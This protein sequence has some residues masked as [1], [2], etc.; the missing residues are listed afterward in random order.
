MGRRVWVMGTSGSG[1]SSL[2][3]EIAGRLG[4]EHVELDGIYHQAGWV[5]LPREEFR[6]RVEQIVAGDEWVVDGNYRGALAEVVW[7]RV[8]TVVWFD[9]PRWRVMVQLVRRTIVRVVTRQVLWN[10]NREPWGNLWSVDPDKSV[11]AWAWTTHA[12]NRERHLAALVDPRYR[13][14]EFVRVGSHAD[15]A[16]FVAGLGPRRG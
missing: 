8:Q 5:A 11:V 10:G 16:R 12:R 1:K 13:H 4:V 14:V 7:D 6:E 2:A 3:R 9:L 15:G